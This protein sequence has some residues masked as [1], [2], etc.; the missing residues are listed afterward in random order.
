[1]RHKV[2]QCVATPKT[3]RS[4]T[5]NIRKMKG[6][7]V[8]TDITGRLIALARYSSAVPALR[9]KRRIRL[10]TLRQWANLD[11]EPWTSN[12]PDEPL[13]PSDESMCAAADAA[14]TAYSIMQLTKSQLIEI[15][16]KENDRNG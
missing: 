7:N 14:R 13:F 12:N 1:M 11:W 6:S 10:A 15:H 4:M 5:L 8:K 3:A 2:S 9:P 16:R